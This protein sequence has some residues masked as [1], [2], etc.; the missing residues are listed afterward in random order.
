MGGRVK[1]CRFFLR[2][3]RVPQGLGCVVV[4]GESLHEGRVVLTEV[5]QVKQDSRGL[6]LSFLPHVTEVDSGRGQE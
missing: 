4:V 3:F 1:R 5:P 2:G 6:L